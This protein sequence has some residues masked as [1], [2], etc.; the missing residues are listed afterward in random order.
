MTLNDTSHGSCRF[1]KEISSQSIN[2]SFFPSEYYYGAALR[3]F[4]PC[5]R[6]RR[7]LEQI[8]INWTIYSVTGYHCTCPLPTYK[9]TP[10]QGGPNLRGRRLVDAATT[11]QDYWSAHLRSRFLGSRLSP[12]I[13]RPQES[14]TSHL[15]WAHEITRGQINWLFVVCLKLLSVVPDE[16]IPLATREWKMPFPDT[17]NGHDSLSAI[18]RLAT[19]ND[20][21]QT[22]GKDMRHT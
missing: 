12:S 3:D 17:V 9:L 10:H 4:A 19:N 2:L 6:Q 16:R 13:K 15:S 7:L 22:N 14:Y 11:A 1:F 5:R 20:V 8:T 18:K 21:P